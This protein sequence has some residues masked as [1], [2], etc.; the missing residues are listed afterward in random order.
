MN[1]SCSNPDSTSATRVSNEE[2][3]MIISSA[4]LKY[5]LYQISFI[6][7]QAIYAKARE[8]ISGFPQG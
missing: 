8:T 6:S 3:L 7:R 1:I 5:F 4:M 2:T